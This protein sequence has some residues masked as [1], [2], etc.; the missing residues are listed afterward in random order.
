M[1]FSTSDFKINLSPTVAIIL[2]ANTFFTCAFTEKEMVK[3][4]KENAMLINF[5]DF[6]LF[7]K[8]LPLGSFTQIANLNFF[9][10]YVLL[11][12]LQRLPQYPL[13]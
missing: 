11:P 6:L 2:S 5:I 10:K 13:L 8:V 12:L 1:A 4:N 3:Q 9:I 7:G